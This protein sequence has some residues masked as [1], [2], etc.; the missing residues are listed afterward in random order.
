[1][2]ESF[3]AVNAAELIGEAVIIMVLIKL[4]IAYAKKM[5]PVHRLKTANNI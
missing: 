5:I 3:P 2:L 4:A 1:L